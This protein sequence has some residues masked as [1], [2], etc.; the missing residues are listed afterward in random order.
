MYFQWLSQLKQKTIEVY[1]WLLKESNY[2]LLFCVLKDIAMGMCWSIIWC[3]N[4]FL[5][6]RKLLIS[7]STH[8]ILYIIYKIYIDTEINKVSTY[9][10]NLIDK[11]GNS[12]IYCMVEHFFGIIFG[13]LPHKI[14]SILWAYQSSEVEEYPQL[15]ANFPKVWRSK[16]QN[17]FHP[18]ANWNILI[19]PCG[20]LFSQLFNK[21]SKYFLWRHILKS[22]NFLFVPRAWL[23]R[24]TRFVLLNGLKNKTTHL[25]ALWNSCYWK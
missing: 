10:R 21:G 13:Y 18:H 1:F 15:S 12:I 17:G 8:N 22:T 5:S 4:I 24:S 7:S 23:L 20:S 25:H 3:K 6:S 11:S 19:H 2:A 16:S 9:L 14:F